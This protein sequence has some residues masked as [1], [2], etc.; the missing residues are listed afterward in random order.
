MASQRHCEFGTGG[1]F[2]SSAHS[3]LVRC[4]SLRAG[5]LWPRWMEVAP[6]YAIGS[7][8]MFWALQRVAALDGS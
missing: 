3:R 5:I 6:A 2:S 4:S 8:A 7:I 1:S